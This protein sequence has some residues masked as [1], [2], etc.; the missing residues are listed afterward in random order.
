MAPPE[1]AKEKRRFAERDATE[2]VARPFGVLL[3]PAAPPDGR[4]RDSERCCKY[5]ICIDAPRSRRRRET[6]SSAVS[7]KRSPPCV[8][9]VRDAPKKG[10]GDEKDA[11]LRLV[12]FVE[13][14][15]GSGIR[16]ERSRGLRPRSISG[17]S[18]STTAKSCGQTRS[19]L[20]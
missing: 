15:G 2:D 4:L 8:V 6:E 13:P 9:N 19:V 17:V 3:R 1:D 16:F 5:G 14:G 12:R 18:L 20:Y 10:D 11:A 7:E